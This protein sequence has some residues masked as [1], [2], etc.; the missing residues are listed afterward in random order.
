M[1]SPETYGLKQAPCKLNEKFSTFLV[2]FGLTQSS[3][4]SCIYFRTGD[5]LTDFIIIGIW[6][7]DGLIACKSAST[8]LAIVNHLKQ[9]F[10][11]TSGPADRFIGLEITRDRR[12]KQLFVTQSGY[13]RQLIDKFSHGG[14]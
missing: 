8:A 12:K 9:H 13:I 14:L 6:V 10:E 11:M 7:H 4:D 1:S 5:H 2:L 3:A